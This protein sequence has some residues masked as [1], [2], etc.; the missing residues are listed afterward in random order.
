MYYADNE[1]VQRA[2]MGLL[3]V[4]HCTLILKIFCVSPTFCFNFHSG[5]AGLRIPLVALS[6]TRNVYDLKVCMAAIYSFLE[7]V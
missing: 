1:H 4:L 3:G 6:S 5:F 7:N 2:A